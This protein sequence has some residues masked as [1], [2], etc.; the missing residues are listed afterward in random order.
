MLE[1]GIFF[2]TGRYYLI[3]SEAG[4]PSPF[5]RYWITQNLSSPLAPQSLV[6][7]LLRTTFPRKFNLF[8]FRLTT[9]NINKRLLMTR[10]ILQAMQKNFACLLGKHENVWANSLIPSVIQLY[11]SQAFPLLTYILLRDG[12]QLRAFYVENLHDT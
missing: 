4:L 11:F 10:L 12:G 9:V 2:A 7:P 5:K 1:N 6:S 3:T 8:P